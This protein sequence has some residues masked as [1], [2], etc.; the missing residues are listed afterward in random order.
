MR[1]VQKI[2]FFAQQLHTMRVLEPSEDF[3][4]G[5]ETVRNIEAQVHASQFV[6]GRIQFKDGKVQEFAY[7]GPFWIE[8]APNDLLEE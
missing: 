6:T 5:L 2:V 1:A 4:P 8:W 3:G 7:C